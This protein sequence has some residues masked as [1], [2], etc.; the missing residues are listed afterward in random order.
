MFVDEPILKELEKE[1]SRFNLF[2]VANIGR[3][4]LVHSDCLAYFLDP[5]ANHGFGT[6]VL[7][8]FLWVIAENASFDRLDFHLATTSEVEVLREWKSIDLLIKLPGERIVIAVE[9]K[10]DSDEHSNQ[11]HRYSQSLSIAFKGWTV[12]KLFLTLDGDPATCEGSESLGY[13]KVISCLSDSLTVLM[14]RNSGGAANGFLSQYIDNLERF[15]MPKNKIGELCLALYAKHKQAIDLIIEH[16]PDAR[17]QARERL[18][19]LLKKDQQFLLLRE[20]TGR[21]EFIPQEWERLPGINDAI[22]TKKVLTFYAELSPNKVNLYLYITPAKD[23]KNREAF[24]QSALA[25]QLT[26]KDQ[27]EKWTRIWAKELANF[28]EEDISEQLETAWGEFLRELPTIEGAF[29]PML[30]PTVA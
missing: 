6:V 16:L 13:S 20:T 30:A 14:A 17:A 10:I 2:Q 1:A 8:R 24:Y 7:D 23:P 3:R 18:L 9:N 29:A 26:N 27:S 21:I 25:A 11:L 19:D 15:I 28:A 4:E 5:A 22:Q 12:L